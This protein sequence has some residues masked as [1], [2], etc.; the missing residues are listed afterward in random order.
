VLAQA[1]QQLGI[2][3]ELALGV[4]EDLRWQ[5]GTGRGH[6]KLDGHGGRREKRRG[7]AG[8]MAGWRDDGACRARVATQWSGGGV[9]LR[10]T[11]LSRDS[12]GL[13]TGLPPPQPQALS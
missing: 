11:S 4:R 7:R 1:V 6:S 2:H 8:G 5:G 12:Q 3:E 9:R 10:A 13:A